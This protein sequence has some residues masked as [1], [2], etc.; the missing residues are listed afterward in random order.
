VRFERRLL[1]HRLCL[2]QGRRDC[3]RI[4]S[5]RPNGRM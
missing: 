5:R 4:A 1:V 2:G 3:R